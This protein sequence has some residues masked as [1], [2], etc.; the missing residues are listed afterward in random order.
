MYFICRSSNTCSQGKKKNNSKSNKLASFRYFLSG[1]R[2]V[3]G[4][5]DGTVR[6]WDLKQGNAIH[7]IKGESGGLQVALEDKASPQC[8]SQVAILDSS[9]GQDGHQGALTCLA[10]NKDGSLVL[11]GSV[12]GY[13]RL[14]NTATGKVGAP[15]SRQHTGNGGEKTKVS[16]ITHSGCLQVIGS[17]SCDSAKDEEESNSVESVGFCNT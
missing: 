6:V 4:Y 8:L 7:V 12:D 16:Q 3:V 5:E 9:A 13:A 1:K 11:T 15:E 14:I 17:F 10:S 2:A